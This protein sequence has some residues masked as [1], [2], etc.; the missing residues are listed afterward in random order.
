MTFALQ[1]VGAVVR[2]AGAT[3]LHDV[4][5][6]ARPGEVVGVVGANGSG[7]TTLARAALGLAKLAGGEARLGGR[8]THGLSELDRADLAAYLPQD[9]RVAWNMPAWRIVALGAVAFPPREARERALAALA[10]VGLSALAERGVR[11]MSGGEQGRVLLARLIVTGAPLLVADEPTAGLD[12]DAA[13]MAMGILRDRA[14]AGAAVI[15]TLHD[16]TLA[17]RAC[18][19]VAVLRAGRLIALDAPETALRSE[20]LRDGF[21]LEGA[22]M[23]SPAGW[24]LAAR[25][26]GGGGDGVNDIR[27]RPV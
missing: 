2:V 8:L 15:A 11:D 24:V 1:L 13:F 17:A 18:D 23:P 7:K 22:L 14:A 6:D 12:P 20:V 21:R 5:L 19:R 4:S 10:E 26:A 27:T 16:L 3:V 9:R 25:R